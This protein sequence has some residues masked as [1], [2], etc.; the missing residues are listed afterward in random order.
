MI[1]TNV[2]QPISFGN[3]LQNETEYTCTQIPSL[4]MLLVPVDENSLGTFKIQCNY[5]W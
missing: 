2:A 3:I 4:V 1:Q 5:I